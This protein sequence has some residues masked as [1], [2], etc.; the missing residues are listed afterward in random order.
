[1]TSDNQLSLNLTGYD[2][3]YLIE[4]FNCPGMMYR[5]WPSE[6]AQEISKHSNDQALIDHFKNDSRYLFYRDEIIDGLRK[7][8]LRQS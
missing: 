6:V 4:V 7:Y 1:M 2:I 3:D 5:W 8:A